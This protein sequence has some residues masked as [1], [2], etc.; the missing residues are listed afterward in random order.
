MM[1]EQLASRS[2][3]DSGA[4]SLYEDNQHIAVE[5][6]DELSDESSRAFSFSSRRRS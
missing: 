5:H 3:P 4:L 2:S 1:S 6:G